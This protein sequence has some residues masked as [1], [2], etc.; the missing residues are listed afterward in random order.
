MYRAMVG[1]HLSVLEGV[2]EGLTWLHRPRI[3]LTDVGGHG[4]RM[5]A[6]IGTRYC[7]PQL[8]S[9]LGPLQVEIFDRHLSV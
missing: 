4:V 6:F 1:V 3:E 9:S 2:R 5:V 7:V 8:D